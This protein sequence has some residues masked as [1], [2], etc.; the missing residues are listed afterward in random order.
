MSHQPV[1]PVPDRVARRPLAWVVPGPLRQVTGG[2]LYD[3]RVVDGLR[4]RGWPV[5][6][7]D[8][9]SSGWPLDLP[10]GR[11]LARVLRRERWGAVVVDELATRRSRRRCWWSLTDALAGAPLV[12]LVHHLRALSR[13]HSDA[14]RR[15]PRRAPGDRAADLVVCTSAT[16]AETVRPL[17]RA[18]TPVEVVRPGWDTHS[19]SLNAAF[20]RGRGGGE[21][22][23]SGRPPGADGRALD[24]A[25]GHPGRSAALMLRQQ[26]SRSI[27]SARPTGTRPMRRAYSSYS[28]SQH[29]QAA[30]AFTVGCHRTIWHASTNRPTR[31]CWRRAT[32]AMGWSWPRVWQPVCQSSRRASGLSGGGSRRPG[33]HAGRVRRR[34]G[35]GPRP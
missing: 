3:A 7:V 25:Q 21:G 11:R 13:P 17:A 28:A 20:P 22:K 4:A 35:T 26:A 23:A 34:R 30:F 1:P 5:G 12:L 29:W 9:R 16:T 24:A 19:R 8:L 33:S 32:K 14:T 10:A 31:C 6:V 2:Y 18:T 15:P 27:E